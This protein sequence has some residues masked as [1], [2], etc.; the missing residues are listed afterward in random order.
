MVQE[1]RLVGIHRPVRSSLA[2]QLFP[3]LHRG[4]IPVAD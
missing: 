3:Q 4:K 1:K 2:L